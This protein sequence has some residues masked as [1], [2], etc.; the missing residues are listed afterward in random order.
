MQ[1][2]YRTFLL[3]QHLLHLPAPLSRQ[4]R[5]VEPGC[6]AWA[7]GGRDGEKRKKGEG[8]RRG[9]RR[10]AL[11]REPW[12]GWVDGNK[13]GCVYDMGADAC[14]AIEANACTAIEEGAFW[15]ASTSATF[16]LVT[17]ARPPFLPLPPLPS[18]PS[19]SSDSPP[20]PPSAE[21]TFRSC[22]CVESADSMRTHGVMSLSS[23]AGNHDWK[24]YLSKEHIGQGCVKQEG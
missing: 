8:V 10:G 4:I 9:W 11:E 13:R 12:R 18:L 17:T 15:K 6:G 2:L 14:T 24:Q 1:R 23:A 21:P 7:G 19:S 16:S 3:S 5:W 22:C 20:D